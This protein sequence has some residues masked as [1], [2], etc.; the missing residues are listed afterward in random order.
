[1]RVIRRAALF[2]GACWLLPFSPGYASADVVTTA[3]APSSNPS[4]AAQ[5][6]SV[7]GYDASAPLVAPS[8]SQILDACMKVE[9]PRMLGMLGNGQIRTR[10]DAAIRAHMVCQLIVAACVTSPSSDDCQRPLSRLGLGDPDYKVSPGAALYDAAERG[11]VEAIRRLLKEGAEP[12]WRN[13]GGWT[14][15]MIAAAEKHLEA[16]E[17]LLQSKADPN[18]RNGYGRTALMFAA[19]YGQHDIVERLLAAGAD[20]NIVPSDQSGWTALIAAAARGHALTVEVLLRSGADPNI[21][22]R[23]GL[24]ALELARSQGHDEIVRILMAASGPR[25]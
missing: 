5:T 9:V 20:P 15:L 24:T 10:E 21:R 22:A 2:V 3:Q 25:T 1:M 14:P 23:D 18:L 13:S 11:W 7:Q 6:Q 12:N 16:V 4:R 8:P 19:A 17:L